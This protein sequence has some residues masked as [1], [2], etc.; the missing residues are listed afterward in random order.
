[1][2]YI[3]GPVFEIDHY[4]AKV[5]KVDLEGF[6]SLIYDKVM[7]LYLLFERFTQNS[8]FDPELCE[9]ITLLWVIARKHSAGFSPYLAIIPYISFLSSLVSFM[10]VRILSTEVLPW[11]Q[12]R[13]DM[14][15]ARQCVYCSGLTNIHVRC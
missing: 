7:H 9:I 1:M 6:V 12:H 5:R 3:G 8:N 11:E 15:S 2:L 13:Q 14:A 4:P 10:V